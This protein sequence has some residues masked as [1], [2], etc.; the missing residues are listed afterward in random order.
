LRRSLGVGAAI[1]SLLLGLLGVLAGPVWAASNTSFVLGQAVPLAESAS[2]AATACVSTSFC[3]SLLSSSS[4]SQQATSVVVENFS[5]SGETEVANYSLPGSGFP[6]GALSCAAES[7]SSSTSPPFPITCALS[8]QE[9]TVVFLTMSSSSSSSGLSVQTYSVSSGGLGATCIAVNEC[10]VL[11]TMARGEAPPYLKI[12]DAATGALVTQIEVTAAPAN[13]GSVVGA[14]AISCSSLTQCALLA[15]AQEGSFIDTV[16]LPSV[17]SSGSASGSISLSSPVAL[18]FILSGVVA[19]QPQPLAGCLLFSVN[20]STGGY[21]AIVYNLATE[22]LG[23]PVSLEEPTTALFV[24]AGAACLPNGYC[25][26]ISE[27]NEQSGYSYLLNALQITGTS[28]VSVVG[29]VNVS[30]TTNAYGLSQF[31]AASPLY[32]GTGTACVLVVPAVLVPFTLAGPTLSVT[33]GNFQWEPFST[34]QVTMDAQFPLAAGTVTFTEAGDSTPLCSNVALDSSGAASCQVPVSDFQY[35]GPYNLSSS[36]GSGTS[37]DSASVELS[38]T[39]TPSSTTGSTEVASATVTIEQPIVTF[40][41][42]QVFPSSN[43]S[44]PITSVSWS[45]SGSVT[46]YGDVGLGDPSNPVQ[47]TSGTV[48]VLLPSSSMKSVLLFCPLSFGVFSCPIPISSLVAT[49]PSA[50]TTVSFT[51]QYSFATQPGDYVAAAQTVVSL[52]VVPPMTLQ[53][54]SGHSLDLVDGYPVA[55]FQLTATVPAAQGVSNPGTVTFSDS[56]GTLCSNVSVPSDGTVICLVSPSA[57]FPASV[58]SSNGTITFTATFT[59]SEGVSLPSQT[60]T[61]AVPVVNSGSS[62]GGS[63][64]PRPAIPPLTVSC[65]AGSTND[66]PVAPDLPPP[67]PSGATPGSGGATPGS[68]N[69]TFTTLPNNLVLNLNSGQV[70]STSAVVSMITINNETLSFT[71]QGSVSCSASG[72]GSSSTSGSGPTSQSTSGLLSYGSP[73]SLGFTGLSGSKPLAAPIIN[74]VPTSDDGGYWLVASDSGVFS[75]GNAKFYGNGYT[76][77]LTGLG[78]SHPLAAPIDDLIPT[79]NDQGYWLLGADGGVFAFGNARFFG[80]TYTAGLTGLSGP[81]QLAEPIVDMVPTSNDQG[82]WLLGEDGRVFAFGNAPYCGSLP[83]KGVQTD[84]AVGLTPSTDGYSIQVR[85]G[86]SVSFSCPA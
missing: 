66:G 57:Y 5:S 40:P 22:S 52:T 61:V 32:C 77:G 39:L 36:S 24:P 34:T 20:D 42:L 2:A 30:P 83:G 69:N 70:S 44:T 14:D 78:G 85:N 35:P 60:A 86:P 65:P 82:Y 76:D 48:G 50:P 1:V 38:A 64:V 8:D 51:V 41:Q 37:L 28:T 62:G 53:E 80:S 43:L 58:V 17:S 72:S 19:C 63:P 11:D 73:E 49:M 33:P 7:S 67:L 26:I 4:N 18:P 46:I 21:D 13:D 29:E 74:A 25:A 16:T 9:L 55:G 27:A 23:Q 47:A 10:L 75:F 15:E 84:Q 6:M 45:A 3:V 71:T 68:V 54:T 59:P 79:S 31:S 81:H 12:F 56:A